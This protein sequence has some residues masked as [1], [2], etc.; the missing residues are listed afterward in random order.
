MSDAST[1]L[2]VSSRTN[3]EK[4]EN[5][6]FNV[7]C[8]HSWNNLQ[9]YLRSKSALHVIVSRTGAVINLTIY[10]LVRF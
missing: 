5:K 3:A 8:P 9:N 6:S 10:I 7:M 2:I 1:R 4:F